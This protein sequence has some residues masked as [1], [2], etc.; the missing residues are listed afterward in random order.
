M[1]RPERIAAA[2]KH[3]RKLKKEIARECGVTPSA[4]TQWV[5]GDSKSMKPENLFALAEATGVSAEW[6][7]NGTGGMT[8]ETSGFDANVEPASGPVRYY[9][10]PEISWV[11]AGMPMEAVEISNVASCEVHPSDAWA[12]PNGFW[13]KVKGP[14]M[15]SSNGMSFPEGMV[16]LVAPGFDV[17]SSQFVVAKMVDTNEATFKQFIWDSGRAFLKPLNP[18]FPTVEMDGEWVLVGR[19]VDAK[20]PRSAL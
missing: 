6:L 12:G 7:A 10:Y 5:T 4:V 17:E 3:S 15:T 9:E 19:V 1:N 16:I 20:W 18:S 13:L 14:S 8:K 11:Q 2:I